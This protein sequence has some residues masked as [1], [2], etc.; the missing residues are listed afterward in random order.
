MFVEDVL[1][2][3]SEDLKDFA[4]T[5]TI[6]GDPIEIQGNTIIPVCRMSIGYGGGGGEGE[7]SDPSKGGGKGMGGGGGG[8]VKI[9]PA[10]LIIVKD[11]EVSVV[12]VQG[13]PSKLG[14]IL[15]MIPEAIEK[16]GKEQAE[17]DGENETSEE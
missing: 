2:R 11:G 6:F 7:G 5:E 1:T 3:L 4:K 15:E 17:S 10:A 9:D 12:A 16:F 13:K 14:A 8:G